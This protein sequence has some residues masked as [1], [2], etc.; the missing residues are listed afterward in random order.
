MAEPIR[1]LQ[2]LRTAFVYQLRSYLRTWR[3]LGLLLFVA[4]VSTVIL[5]VQLHNGVAQ[6]TANHPSA[7]DELSA[8]LAEITNVVVITG[9]F[10]G[11]DALA[12]DLGGGPGY[13]ML[14][15]PVRRR[16]LFAGR[17]LAAALVGVVVSGVYYG[18]AAATVQYFYGTVPAA[19]LLSVGLA[20]L[21]L[22]AVLAL[23]FFFSSFFKSPGVSIVST[24]LILLIGF[25]ILTEAGTLSGVEPWYSLDYGSQAITSVLASNFTHET[26]SHLGLGRKGATLTIYTFLP[27]PWEGALILAVYLVVFVA[28][29]L[30]VYRY[31][32]VRA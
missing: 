10:L 27:Y 7:S 11:G 32:E 24:L 1:D 31:R 22:L 30:A 9:A 26:V 28:L 29:S 16:T 25:P 14:S 13:L 19:I 6:V 2:Q 17:F 23:A 21:F 3:F 8:Y 12:V 15:Q 20:I 18:F 5:V 4:A